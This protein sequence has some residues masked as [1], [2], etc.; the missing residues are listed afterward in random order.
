M[1]KKSNRKITRMIVGCLSM[2][3]IMGSMPV[4]A[5]AEGSD[6]DPEVVS[7]L[8]DDIDP[9]PIN[10]STFPDPV[11]R[12]IVTADH[13][14]NR[15]GILDPD[16]I[17]WGYNIH[18]EKKNVSSIKGVEYFVNLQG[19]YC[20]E[21]NLTEIDVTGLSDL[22]GLWCSGNKLTSIDITKNPKLVWIYCHDNNLTS[23]DV[24]KNP[25]MAFIEI[26]TNPITQLDVSK[27]P[28]LEHLL[29]G[30]CNLTSIDLSKNKNLQH[31]DIFRNP[32][33]K[34]LDV[35]HNPRLKRLNFWD[36]RQLGYVNIRNNTGIQF[37]NVARTNIDKLDV[38]F[39]PE[40]TEL[41]C[42]YNTIEKLDLSHNPKLTI[43]QI[44]NNRI[45]SLDLSKSPNVRFLWAAHNQF[46]SL[47]IG[48][49]PFLLKLVNEGEYDDETMNWSHDC[50][51]GKQWTIDYGGDDSTG[52]THKYQMWMNYNV[53]LDTTGNPPVV[54]EK[55]SPADPGVTPA[56]QLKRE[57]VV[58]YLYELAG[59]PSV[60][61]L[62]NRFTDVPAT[63]P[64]YNAILWAQSHDI[65]TGYPSMAYNTFGL[66]KWLTR[67]DFMYMLMRYSETMGYKRSIDFG[68]SD[69]YMDYYD[70]DYDH[71]EA[72]CWNATLQI[73]AAKGDPEAD[74][75]EQRID[76][77]G[78]VTNTEYQ[79]ALNRLFEVN[80]IKPNNN[81]K[82]NPPAAPTGLVGVSPS[83]KG[84]SD[85]KITGVTTAMEYSTTPNF[86]SNVKPCTSTT[87]TG[88]KAGTYYVRLK[89][90]DTTNAGFAAV[91]IISE[92]QQAPV[93]HTHSA[94]YHAA[95]A[96][97][98]TTAG[99]SAYYSCS[100]GKYF[101]DKAC[102]KEIAKDSWVIKAKGHNFGTPTYTWSKDNLTVTATR[103][104]KNDANHKETEKASTKYTIVKKPTATTTGVGRYTATFKNIDFATQTKDIEI[105]K[106]N[107]IPTDADMSK[108]FQDVVP[109]KW[110]VPAITYVYNHKYMQGVSDTE[111][112]PN[113]ILTRE[114]FVTVLY[115]MEGQPD[116]NYKRTF[117]DVSGRD[118]FARSVFWA[119]SNDIT[120]GI[121]K[122]LFGT[123]QYITRE[124]AATML[125]NY[126]QYKKFKDKK[127]G[128]KISSFPDYNRI[129]TWA[130]EGMQWAVTNHI[131]NGKS[132][133]DGKN[134]LDPTGMATRAECAQIIKNFMEQY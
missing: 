44:Q 17:F 33:L 110:Y 19:L 98:C 117:A 10:A 15:N 38:S 118:W 60:S 49:N 29:C 25:D 87:I 99:N 78:I 55:S 106:I 133:N 103:V 48:S 16:E 105:S 68:R 113:T 26:N 52:G 67:Q 41:I 23:L 92:T 66:G 72:A 21:C 125:Y 93:T 47:N 102:T 84:G 124:Q 104:C 107:E 42:S 111:F 77:Y 62:K 120:K 90:T 50:S 76:P 129:S 28:E 61:G 36:N 69:D 108:I 3:M 56:D 2:I 32:N 88:L 128:T 83:K 27:N 45:K 65:A 112:A 24:S 40:L 13:D 114:M 130:K 74:K 64:Y 31:L 39:L 82:H 81:S 8:W 54:E 18:C 7:A 119:Y 127:S 122:T 86:S 59:S 123:G 12:S 131:I 1:R 132:G 20:Y 58:Q 94:T 80:T 9:V 4:T 14:K 5:F 35:S 89:E 134:L 43:L 34:S 85:G 79:N 100:C 53:K 116:V 70:V 115:N 97:T 51:S 22:R 46:T 101:S 11:F 96:A 71:W 126:A 63:S 6:Q 121:D 75:D 73:V 30:S 109:G 57:V 95:T 37:L 91:V